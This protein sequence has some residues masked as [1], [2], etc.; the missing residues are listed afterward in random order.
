MISH[1]SFQK[2][3]SSMHMLWL[4]CDYF[5]LIFVILESAWWEKILELKVL[6]LL[7]Q[8]HSYLELLFI[9]TTKE[10]YRVTFC[11]SQFYG[12]TRLFW[13]LKCNQI[14]TTYFFFFFTFFRVLHHSVKI[15]LQFN[16]IFILLSLLPS[17]TVEHFSTS[18]LLK[19]IFQKC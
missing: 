2:C 8:L 18:C 13:V 16:H 5:C 4:R 3:G 7:Q 15:Y 11:F 17:V 14:L 19:Y 6:C 10:F 1:I 9:D 12:K